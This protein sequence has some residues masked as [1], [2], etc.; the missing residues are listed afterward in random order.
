MNDAEP[1]EDTQEDPVAKK[2]KIREMR[3]EKVAQARV[4]YFQR[5]QGITT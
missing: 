3:E 1:K 5:Q 4:R 2:R